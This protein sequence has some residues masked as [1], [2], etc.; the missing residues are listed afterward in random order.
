MPVGHG[1]PRVENDARP[2]VRATSL[3]AKSHSPIRLRAEFVAGLLFTWLLLGMAATAHSGEDRDSIAYE[4][5][6]VW[7]GDTPRGYAGTVAVDVGTIE[8]VRNLS[9]QKDAVG[10][11]FGRDG[12]TINV[13][14]HSASLFG[15]IDVKVRGS[16]K[17]R[18][19]LKFQDPFSNSVREYDVSLAE[20][21]QGNWLKPIDERGNRIA[22]ER[23][24]Y[25]RIRVQSKKPQAIFDTG[26]AWSFELSGYRTGLAAGEYTANLRLVGDSKTVGD[27]RQ[28]HVSIDSEGDFEP[29]PIEL[30]TP[31]IEGAYL[32]EITLQ[33]DYRLPTLVLSPE[34]L[35]RRVDLVVFDRQ[36]QA[37]VISQW[38]QVATIDPLKASKPG[39]LAWLSVFD[40]RAALGIPTGLSV[41]ERLQPYNPLSGSFSQPISHG[42]LGARNMGVHSHS[43]DDVDDVSLLTIAA[44]AW[45]ALP[46]NGLATDTPHRLRVRLP[47]DLPMEMAV[48][49]QQTNVSGEFP[50]LSLDS[51]IIVDARQSSAEGDLTEHEVVFWPR[52][53]KA[54]VMLANTSSHHTASVL[55]IFV[56]RA[57]FSPA[58][59]QPTVQAKKPTRMIG[60][61]VDKPLLADCVSA[62]R[63]KDPVTGRALETWSTWQQS[64]L[65]ICQLME[66]REANT[67]LLKC[68]SDGGA[69]FPSQHL[70]PTCRY[71]SGTFFADGRSP[72]V[73]DAVELA[74][75]HFDRAGFHLILALEL[76]QVLPSLDRFEAAEARNS[77]L[78]QSIH[79]G[80]NQIQNGQI[81][82][83]QIQNGPPRYNPLNA[84][85]QEAILV[86]LR[87]IVDRYSGH[88]SFAGIALQID[89]QSQ[90]VF[91]GDRW[92]YDPQTLSS[93]EKSAQIKLPARDRLEE[94]FRGASRLGFLEWRA[95]ELT[96]FY[97]RMG[98][99][100]RRGNAD[101][102]LYLNA[103]RLWDTYP[104]PENFYSPE[105]IIRNPREYLLAF[106]ISPERMAENPQVEL[107]RGCFDT[108]SE[109]VNSQDWIRRESGQRGLVEFY[110]SV[111]SAA[112]VL[113]YPRRYE[114]PSPEKFSSIDTRTIYPTLFQPREF[115]RKKLVNQIFHSDPLLLVEG[116]WLPFSGQDALA[117]P[118]F[119]TLNELPPIKLSQVALREQD[120]N[121]C[122]RQ[123]QYAGNTY[124]QL[125]NNAPWIEQLSVG[126]Q[127]SPN[128]QARV[129]GGREIDLAAQG[130]QGRWSLSIPPYEVI[131]VEIGDPQF[132]LTS[133]QHAPAAGTVAK[134]QQEIA[135]LETL[136]SQ[137]ADLTRQSLLA[138]IDGDFEVWTEAGQPKGWSVSSLP[139]VSVSQSRDLPHTGATSLL[140]E[141]SSTTS[142]SAWVQSRSI[143][144]PRTGRLAVQAWLR[145]PAIGDRIQVKL[146]IVG[147]TLDDQRFEHSMVLGTSP[148]SAAT[149]NHIAIDWGRRP[150]TLYVSNIS[151]ESVAELYVSIELISRGKVWIDD[152]QVYEAYLQPEERNH[153]RG[154][155]LVAKQCLTE[156]N[157]FPAEQLLDSHW[158]KYLSRF[159]DEKA[160]GLRIATAVGTS[161]ELPVNPTKANAN[162][163]ESPSLFRQFRESVRDRW[164]Q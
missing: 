150:A 42:E 3:L 108:V 51:G 48:S 93:F 125:V 159:L 132:K 32:L 144:P 80:D 142:V 29:L 11:V 123:G 58:D 151:S 135:V 141:N 8:V 63:E 15:G 121:L 6:I 12:K 21:L 148:D 66:F 85:V 16:L 69:I 38:K 54:Y 152:V 47:T 1:S 127:C 62:K 44:G 124:L 39:S 158:G 136:I 145:A 114:L 86:A 131:G 75:R 64:I 7:G 87:E 13:V 157:A 76:N 101:A 137:S 56:E 98:E 133:I 4:L 140:I 105:T 82:N 67:L 130:E 88:A 111:D 102:K 147:R 162:W 27:A 161:V 117:R 153:L 68:F 55:D 36:V 106:G 28:F 154:Q 146:S 134:V 90:L 9:L 92:G 84:Q 43:S 113:R 160:G 70:Q 115:A 50:P 78:Q 49:L 23:Q 77:L 19:L 112:V 164:K 46:L 89:E 18:L 81:Q 24:T 120:S 2:V 71:D 122:V 72:E 100:V 119:R 65:R 59:L 139:Q 35:V 5:R 57:E 30:T 34:S 156:N 163:S 95:A 74:L 118:L 61:N 143:Q 96:K 41:V 149:A 60:I 52:G 103:I 26:E 10:T 99:V 109:S 94:V 128:A 104:T 110:S 33:R 22:I 97:A 138:N 91:A 40:K 116:G 53:D 37:R 79:T 17:S 126:Y 73:K 83:G 31:S 155:L 14:A 129:L 20:L 45:L 25:D 107:M